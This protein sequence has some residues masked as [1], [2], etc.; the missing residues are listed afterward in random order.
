MTEKHFKLGEL[1]HLINGLDGEQLD[2]VALIV[3]SLVG[4]KK[5]QD[6]IYLYGS[7][8][9]LMASAQQSFMGSDPNTQKEMV[10]VM[11]DMAVGYKVITR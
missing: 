1:G 5:S 3:R 7:D 6:G 2:Y 9:A 8:D 4:A 11:A 10:I